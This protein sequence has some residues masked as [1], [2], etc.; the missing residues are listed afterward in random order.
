MRCSHWP[1]ILLLLCFATGYVLSGGC[2]LG[3]KCSDEDDAAICCLHP[4]LNTDVSNQTIPPP[5]PAQ[6]N[7]CPAA[8]AVVNDNHVSEWRHWLHNASCLPSWRQLQVRLTPH[9]W[10]TIL[11]PSSSSNASC[12]ARLERLILLGTFMNDGLYYLRAA[13]L[14]SLFFHTPGP[15]S[16]RSLTVQQTQLR[17]IE[18][19]FMDQLN[20]PNVMDLEIH[21]NPQ[22]TSDGLGVG[23]LAS[24]PHLRLLDLSRNRLTSINLARWGFSLAKPSSL[25]TLDLSGNQIA[26]LKPDSF[27]RVS[28]IMKLDLS[29]NLLTSLPLSVFA[30]LRNLRILNL[31]ANRLTLSGLE[32]PPTDLLATLPNLRHLQLSANPLLS[33]NA[34]SS[35]WWLNNECPRYLTVVNFAKITYNHA[36]PPDLHLMLPPIAWDR[37][38]SLTQLILSDI[39]NLPCLSQHWLG[40]PPHASVIPERMRIQPGSLRL[41]PPSST[42]SPPSEL[43]TLHPTKNTVS[44]TVRVPPPTTSVHTPHPLEADAVVLIESDATVATSLFGAN[45]PPASWRKEPRGAVDLS[46]HRT[47]RV[48]KFH[49][50]GLKAWLFYVLI[51]LLFL[52][53]SCILFW[54]SV[55]FFKRC[56]RKKKAPVSSLR[57]Q[58]FRAALTNGGLPHTAVNCC[59]NVSMLPSDLMAPLELTL[60]GEKSAFLASPCHFTHSRM[61]LFTPTDSGMGDLTPFATQ[62]SVQTGVSPSSSSHASVRVPHTGHVIQPQRFVIH[63]A[64]PM[65]YHVP[66][67]TSLRSAHLSPRGLDFSCP[68]YRASYIATPPRR[69]GVPATAST[70]DISIGPGSTFSDHLMDDCAVS[71]TTTF[72]PSDYHQESKLL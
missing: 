9:S 71:D 34:S 51:F 57:S 60:D 70:E 33:V 2:L 11:P 27:I 52:L 69:S 1:H 41:C 36:V 54:G 38:A 3:C 46:E 13:T 68:M 65:R 72:R 63:N 55:F 42:F 8:A 30:G 22:L 5:T 53:V 45:P 59:P 23:W 64:T 61:R 21:R 28:N 43:V 32:L 49:N 16:L 66:S 29:D 4:V 17:E 50:F 15:L 26:H 14:R 25:L 24:L 12:T 48:L 7:V 56:W 20:A 10:P 18:A 6:S 37:C 39:H 58:R 62:Q 67:F 35:R 19:G 47:V 40:I 31:R 44:I